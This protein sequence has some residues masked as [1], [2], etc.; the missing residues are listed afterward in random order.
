MSASGN[1]VRPRLAAAWIILMALAAPAPA[2]AQDEAAPETAES[3]PSP[4]ETTEAGNPADPAPTVADREPAPEDPSPPPE[5][6]PVEPLRVDAPLPDDRARLDEVTVNAQKRGNEAIKDIPISISVVDEHLIFDWGITNVREVMLFV[7]NVKVEEAGYFMLPRIRG[8]STNN[9]NKAFEPPAGVALDGIPYGRVEYFNAG[10]FDIQRVEVLRGPQG[11]TFGKNTTAGLIH[12]I[13]K[14]PSEDFNGFVDLQRGDYDRERIEFGLGGALID[15]LAHLRIAGM[16]DTRRGF[17]YN[18]TAAIS[19]QADEYLQGKDNGGFRAKLQF[20]DLLGTNLKLS[21]ENLELGSLGSGIEAIDLTDTMEATLRKYDPDA[22]FIKGNF[23]TSLDYPDRRLTDI[24]TFAADW[25]A[26]LGAWNL[27]A[28]GGMSVMESSFFLDTDFSPAPAILG[29]GYDR[30][31]TDTLELRLLSPSFGGLFGLGGHGWG[32]SD[33]LIGV[34]GQR[35]AIEDGYF[36]FALPVVPFLDLTAAAESSGGSSE[37]PVVPSILDLIPANELFLEEGLVEAVRQFFDQHSRTEAVF[38]QLQWRFLPDWALQLAG[39]YS[40]E[41]KDARWDSV[42]TTPTGVVLKAAGIDEFTAAREREDEFFQPKVSLNWQPTDR[43]SLFVHW[44]RSFKAGGF[45]AF[46]FR[47]VDD[48]LGFGPEYTREWGADL[49]GTF[50]DRT[51]KLNLS[52]YNMDVE[53]FQVLTREPQQADADPQTGEITLSTIG[54][55]ITKVI[56]APRA[57]ARGIEGDVTWLT[58]SWLRWFLTVGYNDTEYLDHKN[59]DCA[60]DLDAPGRPFC[61]ATGKPFAFAPK[62][63]GSITAQLT[64]PWRLGDIELTSAVSGEYASWQYA[65]IDLD[66]RKIQDAY[67]RYRASIGFSNPGQGWSF[68]VIGENL[69]DE[70]TYIR[71]GDLAPKQFVGITEPPRQIYGQ[72]RWTF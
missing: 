56:N 57:R 1:G 59:N 42:Y 23:K 3:A 9:N 49:K 69:T 68:K 28:I 13:S 46:A 72:L 47:N 16:S 27:A 61:D 31:P 55:G 40:R 67:W 26:A 62:Y 53:D 2:A 18:T 71:Q 8:F 52:A 29:T 4:E 25:N 21:Y 22:D 39:R 5:T 34:F 15:G 6:I 24:R 58:A 43:L 60:P 7:P 37:A 64:S 30:A 48:Q 19:P 65:D 54:L 51:L 14:D 38:A 33:I 10:L 66:D 32:D 44:A 11:T 41:K 20:P 12:I 63:N 35:T 45:N 50:F 36:D 70:V 17:I